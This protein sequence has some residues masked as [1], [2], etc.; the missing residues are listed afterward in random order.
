MRLAEGLY[1]ST[2]EHYFQAMKFPD[3]QYSDY[4]EQIRLARSPAIAKKLGQTRDYP[5]REDWEEVKE[6]VMLYA[7]RKKFSHP[8]MQA[9]LLRT[10]ERHLYENSPYDYYWGIGKDHEGQNRLGELLMLVR[11]ELSASI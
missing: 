6:K 1:W 11:A 8:K 3:Q 10:R 2:V 5:L 9:K 7:L 4:R